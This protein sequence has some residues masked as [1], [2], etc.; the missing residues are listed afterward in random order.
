MKTHIHSLV[1]LVFYRFACICAMDGEKMV[2]CV[3]EQAM[4]NLTYASSREKEKKNERSRKLTSSSCISVW[5]SVI[6]FSTNFSLHPAEELRQ[7]TKK[8]LIDSWIVVV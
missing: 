7:M 6:L 3:Y 1:S 2:W 8:I 5:F 4:N